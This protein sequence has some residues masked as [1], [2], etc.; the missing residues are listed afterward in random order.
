MA[1]YYHTDAFSTW[2]IMDPNFPDELPEVGERVWVAIVDGSLNKDTSKAYSDVY[3]LEY[4]GVEWLN[5]WYETLHKSYDKN[6]IVVWVKIP[7]TPKLPSSWR[8]CE[9]K[10]C[11]DHRC[12]YYDNGY[13]LSGPKR[14]KKGT[15]H[16]EFSRRDY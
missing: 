7:P 8:I 5:L 13:C 6:V 4:Q 12:E 16:P 15:A 9:P 14:C 1:Y 11:E 2:N 10:V 3:T